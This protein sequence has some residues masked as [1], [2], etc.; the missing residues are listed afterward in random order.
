MA[1]TISYGAKK[2]GHGPRFFRDF[3]QIAVAK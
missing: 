1:D 3:Y 2:R